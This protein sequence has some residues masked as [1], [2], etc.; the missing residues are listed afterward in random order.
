MNLQGAHAIAKYLG[1]EYYTDDVR[2]MLRVLE[3]KKIITDKG[4]AA[5]SMTTTQADR[6]KKMI[7]E[8]REVLK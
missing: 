8:M 7:V 4:I 1:K 5:F 2:Y 3:V 6:L